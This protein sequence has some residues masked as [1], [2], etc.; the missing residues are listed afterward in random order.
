MNRLAVLCCLLAPLSFAHADVS[1]TD[2]GAALRGHGR[3]NAST[4]TVRQAK[5]GDKRNGIPLDKFTPDFPGD[6]RNHLF[7]RRI[8][9]G[10]I[11]IRCGYAAN[12]VLDQFRSRIGI[13]SGMGI[14]LPK[15]AGG[16]RAQMFVPDPM[17]GTGQIVIGSQRLQ[18]PSVR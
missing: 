17:A 4:T 9:A 1:V 18:Q 14:Y 7:S 5:P 12:P 15:A 13:Q 10:N 8:D 6:R 11:V 2:T 16:I 3:A